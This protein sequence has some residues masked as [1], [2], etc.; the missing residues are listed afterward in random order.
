MILPPDSR[1]TFM[2]SYCRL[3]FILLPKRNVQLPRIHSYRYLPRAFARDK[4]KNDKTST[5]TRNNFETCIYH[6]KSQPIRQTLTHQT[7]TR[8]VSV[9]MMSDVT[10]ARG[11][12]RKTCSARS[13][14]KG[15]R[16][17]ETSRVV[18]R[19]RIRLIAMTHGR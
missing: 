9:E 6:Y 1:L 12:R 15:S 18:C 11:V 17:D 16:R 10:S 14:K 8:I 13:R 3:K 5:E 7:N 2:T 19:P 4:S